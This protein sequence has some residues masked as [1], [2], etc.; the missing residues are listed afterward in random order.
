MSASTPRSWPL[1]IVFAVVGVLLAVGASELALRATGFSFR[2]YPEKL[3]FGF[4]DPKSLGRYFVLHDRYLWAQSDYDERIRKA[5]EANPDVVLMGCSCTEWGKIDEGLLAVHAEEA[6]DERELVVANLGC[7]GWSSYQGRLQL[8]NDV[9]DIAPRAIT[10]FYGWNDHWIGFGIEDKHAASY[11]SSFMFHLQKL[12]LAQLATRFVVGLEAADERK[13]GAGARPERVSLEDFRDN[14]E[15]MVDM[16][17]AKGIVPILVTAPTTAEEGSE[18]E[19]LAARHLNDVTDLVPLHRSYV[20][21][22]RE[23][24]A[25]RGV[26]LC[27]LYAEFEAMSKEEA[28]T[29]IKEDAIHFTPEGGA[30][31]AASMYE[32]LAAEGLVP[33]GEASE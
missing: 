26:P 22:V 33:G 9:L 5:R 21:V 28:S 14:L 11:S 25:E 32:I 4:P 2:L 10:I 6:P 27:D 29:Y 7:S 31:V 8:E 13:L 12:R 15:T 24:A 3:E 20:E 23:V 16:A 17:T 1:R 19:Y 18:P 30:R